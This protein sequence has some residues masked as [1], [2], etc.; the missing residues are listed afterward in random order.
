MIIHIILNEFLDFNLT[1]KIVATSA[2]K[3]LGLVMAKCK[4]IGGVSY[5]VFKKVFD[6][7]VSPIIEY[8][9]A[10]WGYKSYSYSN[11]IQMPF[12][13]VLVDILPTQV[14]WVPWVGFQFITHNG[15]YK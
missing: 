12:F 9:A 1:A 13:L 14:S 8:G 6:S 3:A 15:N 2:N 11:A 4:P 7:L 10:I 5:D